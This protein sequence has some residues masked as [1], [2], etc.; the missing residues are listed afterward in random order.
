MKLKRKSLLVKSIIYN[1]ISIILTSIVV[2]LTMS[3]IIFKG[4]NDK[5]PQVL[6]DSS[7][8]IQIS[9]THFIDNVEG[10]L[11]KAISSG[12]SAAILSKIDE[13]REVEKKYQKNAETITG[14]QTFLTNI[15]S[16]FLNVILNKLYEDD[17][18]SNDSIGVS[19]ADYNGNIVSEVLKFDNGEKNSGIY[20]LNKNIGDFKKNIAK[21]ANYSY[22]NYIEETNELVF[23]VYIQLPDKYK[24]IKYVVISTLVKDEFLEKIRDYVS[25]DKGVKL[26]ILYDGIYINGDF[27]IERGK[28]FFS[29]IG[30]SKNE[31]KQSEERVIAG[32][33]YSIAYS[34]I[35]D[36]SEKIIGLIGLGITKDS[37]YEFSLLDYAIAISVILSLITLISYFFGKIY[38]KQFE[39]LIEL[40]NISKEISNGN[41]DVKIKIKAEGEI[42]ELADTMKEMIGTIAVNNKD[43]E[44]KNTRLRDQ[45][46]RIN[47]IEKLLLNIHSEDNLDTI[48]FY[49]LSALTSEIGLDYGRTIYLEYDSEQEILKGKQSSTNIKFIDSENEYYKFQSG[50]KLHSESLD[51]VVKL[52]HLDLDDNIIA[53]CFKQGKIICHN[54]RGF[55]FKLGSDLLTSL[56]LNNFILFPIFTIN[57][58]YGVIIIDQSMTKRTVQEDDI[59]LLNL[60]SMNISIHFKNK[61][62][63]KEKISSEKDTTISYL[64]SKILREIQGPTEII[65]DI[66]KDY[67]KNGYMEREKLIKIQKSISKINDLSTSVLEYADIGPIDYEKLDLKEIVD[68]SIENIKHLLQGSVIDLSKLYTHKNCVIAN[69]NKLEVAMTEILINAV[70]AVDRVGGRINIT[71]K[72]KSGGVQIKITD[73]GL[74][75]EEKNIKRIFDPFVSFKG[76]SGLGLAIA[77]KIVTEHGGEIRIKSEPNKGTEIRIMLNIYEEE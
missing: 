3:F 7:E 31:A 13:L 30:F 19:I 63:E 55:K 67:N 59:E 22:F 14:N 77:K 45:I 18:F 52:I 12:N 33:K 65:K 35:K 1:D 46:R 2:F 76:A 6:E 73:N 71:T 62:L 26:F 70:E 53:D 44:Q 25:L 38:K 17:Y 56:G 69:R 27:D 16:E 39:P 37:I 43:L 40:K 64:S 58:T 29:S 57:K 54:D 75:V 61:E 5:I 60:L 8:K 41:F 11:V 48:I 66:F 28:N 23:R 50:L 9:Y 51:K 74:G 15:S 4:Q 72:N 10:N 20:S 24:N 34:Q 36:R 68:Q 49:M 32:K 21:D 47:M 42:R